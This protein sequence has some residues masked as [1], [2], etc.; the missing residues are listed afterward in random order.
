MFQEG[1]VTHVVAPVSS[2]LRQT[3]FVAGTDLAQVPALKVIVVDEVNATDDVGEQ[4]EHA[5]RDQPSVEAI[6]H[7]VRAKPLARFRGRRGQW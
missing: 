4:V 1:T 7:V 6:A 5:H 3:C 2:L